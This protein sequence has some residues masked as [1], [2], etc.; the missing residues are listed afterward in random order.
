MLSQH[1]YYTLIASLPHLPMRFGDVERTPITQPRLLERLRLLRPDDRKV[2]DQVAAF[3]I[4]D[5]QPLDNTDEQVIAR[6]DT[7]MDT[8][9]NPLVRQVINHRIDVRT[10]IS[11]LR[12]RRA[13]DGP[14]PGLGQW[15]DHIRRNWNHPE[16][17]LGGRYPWISDVER[18]IG[19]GQARE[20]QRLLFGVTYKTWSQMAERYT[21]SFETVILYLA[22]WEIIDRWTSQN[23]DAGRERFDKLITETLGVYANI[24]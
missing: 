16:F 22:R 12:R 5:R 19:E 11:A 21:F 17:N 7:L 14:P 9:S 10:I 18:M 23:M 24:Y 8:V 15:V 20:T 6:Y 4:W 3:L 1:S 2:I 13:G